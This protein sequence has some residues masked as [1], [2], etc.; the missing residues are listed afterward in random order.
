[1]PRLQRSVPQV[2]PQLLASLELDEDEPTCPDWATL[3]VY[4]CSR[5]CSVPHSGAAGDAERSAYVEE[6]VWVQVDR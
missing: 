6:H 1:M 5:A 4:S 2:L 3:A